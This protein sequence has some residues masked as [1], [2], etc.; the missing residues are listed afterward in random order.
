MTPAQMRELEPAEYRAFVRLMTEHA[1]A[2][3]RGR[4]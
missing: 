2:L 3:K 1:R 4:R